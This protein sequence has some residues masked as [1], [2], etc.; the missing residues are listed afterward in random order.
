MTLHIKDAGTWKTVNNV[1]VKDAGVWKEVNEI[2]IKDAGVWKNAFVNEFNIIISSNQTNLNLRSLALSSGWNEISKL[3]VTINAGI[4]ISS[5]TTSTPA[6]TISGAFQNGLTLINNGSVV[7]MGGAGNQ[8]APVGA[9]GGNGFSGGTAL[10][11][12]SGVTIDNASGVIAGGGGGGGGGGSFQDN[13][14][15]YGWAGG[16]GGG[17][18]SG[19]TN[20]AAGAAG[21]GTYFQRSRDSAAG[22]AGTVSAAG[23]GGIGA[24]APFA[25]YYA[26]AGGN[27]GS[28]GSAGSTGGSSNPP[29]GH[30]PQ[31]PG[32]GGTAGA[33]V[34]GNSNITWTAFG[35]RLGTIS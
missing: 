2:Y 8:G 33:A 32:S 30:T 20:S 12:S 31:P 5:N 26:G 11:V 15:G 23:S 9:P 22:T 24:A 4:Y 25:Q 35:T 28:W 3:I 17:G 18:Q 7:G 29:G 21:T 16:G 19:L 27:G 34:S 14:S 6:L 13:D 10:S 1:Y